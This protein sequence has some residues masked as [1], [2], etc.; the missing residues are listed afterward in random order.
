M[1]F[2]LPFVFCTVVAQCIRWCQTVFFSF[3]GGL[4]TKAPGE[5]W[6]SFLLWCRRL[7]VMDPAP[8]PKP[9][10]HIFDPLLD[11]LHL[12]FLSGDARRGFSPPLCFFFLLST[13]TPFWRL[14][15]SLLCLYFFFLISPI[16]P[17]PEVGFF[18]FFSLLLELPALPMS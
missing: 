10:R 4:L 7:A 1:V 13:G 8:R 12:S 17:E 2:S 6:N 14:T 11:L 5:P 16:V 18:F 15:D 9:F 3:P